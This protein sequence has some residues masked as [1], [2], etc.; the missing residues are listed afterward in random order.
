MIVSAGLTVV[1]FAKMFQIPADLAAG[2]FAGALTSTPAL[3]AAA[4]ALPAESQ[5]AVGFGIA[6]PF[7]AVAVVIFVQLAPKILRLLLRQK[8]WAASVESYEREPD[9][10]VRQLVEVTNPNVAGKCFK[11]MPIFARC[12]IQVSRVLVGDRMIPVTSDFLLQVGLHVLIIG[13]EQNVE[14]V[15]DYIGHKSSRVEYQLDLESQ[16]RRVVVTSAALVGRTLRETHLRSKFGVTI[17]R[18]LRHDVEFVPNET[19]KI[20]FGDALTAIGEPDGLDRFTKFAG[21]RE[22]SFDETDMISLAMGL[23]LGT[24]IGRVTVQLG[25]KSLSLGMAGGPLLVGLILGH[26]GRIGPIVGHFPRASRLLL[27]DLG[28]AMFLASAGV[29]AGENMMSVIQE[30]GMSL[31]V[32]ACAVTTVPLVVGIFVTTWLLKMEPLQ[33]L[34]GICGAMTSTPGLGALMSQSDSNAP[35]TS[36][37]TVYPLALILMSLL[38]PVLIAMLQ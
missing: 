12:N 13:R 32:G 34:G 15:T 5:L 18:I 28:L 8:E 11:Q 23:V 35:V 6:Y 19:Q 16:R 1:V 31:C 25:P 24:L 3:A 21:H 29:Q 17:T 9:R 26:F 2:I 27:T 37:A 10:I 36:Y 4:E 7:G 30:H 20:E 33:A 14:L 22:R 38:G